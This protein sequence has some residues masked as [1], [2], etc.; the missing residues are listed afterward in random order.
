MATE[1]EHVVASDLG[2][3]WEPNSSDPVLIQHGGRAAL[4]VDPH[5]E[6]RD[7]RLVV[8][9]V[10]GCNG[11]RLGPPN[12]EG[13]PGHRLWNKGLA[14]CL[15]TGEVLNSRGDR[16]A[17]EGCGRASSAQSRQQGH[18]PTLDT[19]LQRSHRRS[20]RHASE[21]FP[22]GKEPADVTPRQSLKAI[23]IVMRP[24]VADRAR[25]RHRRECLPRSKKA[26]ADLGPSPNCGSR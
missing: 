24:W 15:W 2:V 19:L 5:F 12:D 11:V 16:G 6:D 25:D 26:A 20:A 13:R 23:V 8:V 1:R 14:N 18:S 22:C 21:P 9:H 17:G 7:R 10:D 3:T 4:A